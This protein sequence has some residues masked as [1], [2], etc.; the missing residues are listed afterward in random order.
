MPSPHIIKDPEVLIDIAVA[1]KKLTATKTSDF[2]RSEFVNEYRAE[3]GRAPEWTD[4]TTHWMYNAWIAAQGDREWLTPDEQRQVT[5]RHD[6]FLKRREKMTACKAKQS[7]E[8]EELKLERRAVADA[9][10]KRIREENKAKKNAS[11][12][13]P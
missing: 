5:A 13:N 3:H 7:L 8:R 12:T 1:R 11:R 2:V 9:E 10:Y 4:V 6:A